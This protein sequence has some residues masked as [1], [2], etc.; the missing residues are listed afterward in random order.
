MTTQPSLFDAPEPAPAAP[1][2]FFKTDHVPLWRVQLDRGYALKAAQKA[3][4]F[5]MPSSRPRLKPNAGPPMACAHCHRAH[6]PL[7]RTVLNGTP[8]CQTC[9]YKVDPGY[10][11]HLLDNPEHRQAIIDGTVVHPFADFNYAEVRDA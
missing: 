2:P 6:V 3:D 1:A 7:D 11:D 8:L 10:L 5:V 4:G 9:C